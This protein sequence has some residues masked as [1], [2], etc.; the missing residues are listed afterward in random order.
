MWCPVKGV[1]EIQSQLRT[2]K[3]PSRG[4]EKLLAWQL[5]RL[6]FP[7][8]SVTLLLCGDK[9]SRSLNRRFRGKD[10]STDI[11]SFPAGE[12]KAPAGSRAYLGDL[13]LN[14]PYSWRRRGRFARSFQGEIA[15]LTAHGL[16]HL[17]GYD[18]DTPGRE[19]K[20][21]DFQSRAD[22]PPARLRD[23]LVFKTPKKRT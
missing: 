2:W 1:V 4:L 3:V 20:M 9:A 16:C 23:A 5:G 6:G 22:A 14:V 18:H 17:I 13:A 8:A 15:F 10:S 7:G 19:K 11:L 21:E 12:G